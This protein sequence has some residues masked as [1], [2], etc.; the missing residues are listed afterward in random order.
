MTLQMEIREENAR[1]EAEEAVR[2]EKQEEEESEKRRLAEEEK[3]RKL[4]EEAEREAERVQA[5]VDSSLTDEKQNEVRCFVI[6]YVITYI[7]CGSSAVCFDSI[8]PLTRTF[9]QLS[10]VNGVDGDESS[11]AER[12]KS[13]PDLSGQL[14]R[15]QERDVDGKKA[16]HRL[17]RC[18]DRLCLIRESDVIV[19]GHH[20]NARHKQA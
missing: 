2:R 19:A 17:V 18:R 15:K 5:I 20:G 4:R 12:K 10:F 8:D 13:D 7:S 14:Q 16:P 1:R 3:E 11:G 9:F 6:S